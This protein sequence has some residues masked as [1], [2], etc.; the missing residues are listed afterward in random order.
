MPIFA[1]PTGVQM[2]VRRSYKVF[3]NPWHSAL[4]MIICAAAGIFLLF[5]SNYEKGLAIASIKWPKTEGRITSSY[6]SWSRGSWGEASIRYSYWVSGIEYGGSTIV[7]NPTWAQVHCDAQKYFPIN[8]TVKVYYDPD[9]LSNSAFDSCLQ[10]GN[11][12]TLGQNFYVAVLCLTGALVFLWITVNSFIVAQAIAGNQALLD[13]S[14][15]KTI[16][17]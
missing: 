16:D 7:F 2:N 15:G 10:L 13:Q 6:N 1:Y 12:D 8:S 5:M 3:M 4:A 11:T 9:H 17:L 14:S